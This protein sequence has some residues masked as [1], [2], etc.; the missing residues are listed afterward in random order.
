MFL[1]LDELVVARLAPVPC[2][3]LKFS[4]VTRSVIG[5]V[6]ALGLGRPGL[7][8]V[9][10]DWVR[11]RGVSAHGLAEPLAQVEAPGRS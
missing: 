6:I 9:K 5:D 4:S 11:R 10:N 8:W 7:G 3:G 1:Q 2:G